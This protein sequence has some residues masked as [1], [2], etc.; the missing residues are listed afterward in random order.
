MDSSIFQNKK[1]IFCIFCLTGREE[2]VARS[3]Q[4]QGFGYLIPY[5]H[6]LVVKHGLS[7]NEQR[8]LFPGY[9]FIETDTF[10]PQQE[11]GVRHTEDVIKILSYENNS[12]ALVGQD[13]A[14]LEW[15][16]KKNGTI[17]ISHV[18][19]EGAKLRIIDGPLKDREGSIVS[20]NLKRRCVAIQVTS[21]NML[22]KIWCSIELVEKVNDEYSLALDG[23][24]QA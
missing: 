7:M 3:L 6:R 24:Q 21:S 16:W 11:I 15:L 13:R 1:Y 2:S 14:F 12:Y 20:I 5:S 23:Q 17:E 19:K 22:G 18:F 8:K 9:V 4:N 10:V